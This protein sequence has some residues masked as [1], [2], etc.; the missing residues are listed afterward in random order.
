MEP[1]DANTILPQTEPLDQMSIDAL[2][3]ES[4]LHFQN[5]EWQEAIAGFEKVLRLAPDNAQAKAFLEEARLKAS[6]DQEKPKPKKHFRIPSALKKAVLIA[7][8]LGLVLALGTG[9]WWAY[10]RWV[11]PV[12]TAQQESALLAQQLQ[13]AYAYL[14]SWDYAAAEEAFRAVLAKDPDNEE[15]NGE[16]DDSVQS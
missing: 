4:L 15:A 5:G 9:L 16:G 2:Y 7:A 14:A 3:Q 13:Q 6:L 12:K 10:N 1:G 11:Q 8:A